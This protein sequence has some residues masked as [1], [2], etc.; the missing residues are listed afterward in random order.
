MWQ[1]NYRNLGRS[2]NRIIVQKGMYGVLFPIILFACTLHV[3]DNLWCSKNPIITG[4]K[5][6]FKLCHCTGIWIV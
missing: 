2:L 1:C 6:V 4:Y 5:K 3:L